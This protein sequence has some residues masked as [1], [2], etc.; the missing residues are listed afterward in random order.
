ME[1]PSKLQAGL[2]LLHMPGFCL[3]VVNIE[4]AVYT[5]G[6]SFLLFDLLNEVS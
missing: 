6:Y 2:M 4:R 5:I 3:A 1:I